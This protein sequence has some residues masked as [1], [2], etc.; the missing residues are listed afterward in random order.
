MAVILSVA[1]EL[2][3][4][5]QVSLHLTFLNLEGSLEGS[6]ETTWTP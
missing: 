1:V 5:F 4:K 6:S 2:N 3:N